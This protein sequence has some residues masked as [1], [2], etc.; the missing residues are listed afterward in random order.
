M[1]TAQVCVSAFMVG[2]EEDAVVEIIE[3]L[4]REHQDIENLLRVMER[5]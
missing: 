2:L 3:I 4:R 1:P 5:S